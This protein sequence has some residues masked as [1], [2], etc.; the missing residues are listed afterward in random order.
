MKKTNIQWHPA[1]VSAMQLEFKEDRDKL[2]FEK[3][4]NLNTKPLQIDLLIIRKEENWDTGNEIGKLFRKYNIIEY[5][6]PKQQLDID[7]FYK[8]QSYAGLYKS[9]GE[10]LDGRKA[11]DITFSIV[12][13]RKPEKLFRYFAEQGID[14]ENPYGGIYY[15]L[16][17]VLFPTQIIV[18]KELVGEP[19]TWLKA[20]TDKMEIGDMHRLLKDTSRLEGKLDK[21]FADSILEVCLRANRQIIEKLEGDDTMSEALLEIIEP[22]IEPMMAERERILEIRFQKKTK[23]EVAKMKKEGIKDTVLLL[24]KLGHNNDVIKTAIMEQY[25]LSDEEVAKYL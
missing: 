13:D 14:V 7:V 25:H 10:T 19:H 8:T 21:E 6:S 17:E 2:S 5:K 23:E 20:L 3:E 15:I 1:F 12:R 24:H 16:G 18:T 4:H 9:Y 22:L 11:K